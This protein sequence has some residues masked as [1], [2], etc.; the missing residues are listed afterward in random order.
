MCVEDFQI[1]QKVCRNIVDSLVFLF[2]PKEE[3]VRNFDQ[4]HDA[5]TDGTGES[6]TSHTKVR[7]QKI[8]END[9]QAGLNKGSKQSDAHLSHASEKALDAVGEGWK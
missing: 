6:Y 1:Q 8:D 9:T 2:V 5:P 7:S 3:I 4:K